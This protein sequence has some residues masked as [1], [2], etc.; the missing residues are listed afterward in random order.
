MNANSSEEPSSSHMFPSCPD[1]P[2]K[3]ENV[4]PFKTAQSE[5]AKEL[6][7][8]HKENVNSNADEEASVRLALELMRQESWE[9]HRI[10]Q[11]ETL[12]AVQESKRQA[13][14]LGK[15]QTLDEDMQL[16]LMLA[17]EEEKL[18]DQLQNQDMD[19][20]DLD[21][22]THEELVDLG[23]RIGSVKQENWEKK[24]EEAV[25][26]LPVISFTGQNEFKGEKCLVCQ[27]EYEEGEML[28]RLP[29]GHCF[30]SGCITDWLIKNPLCPLCKRPILEMEEEEDK[31]APSSSSSSNSSDTG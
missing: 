11:S 20:L 23:N 2:C 22:M 3:T 8:T 31:A 18:D 15:S 12:L 6:K 10:M 19:D 16:A 30:H 4:D 17:Q 5:E 28:K 27:C 26:N 13:M 29:C 7:T 24:S 9:M 1:S 25:A 14:N 21:E